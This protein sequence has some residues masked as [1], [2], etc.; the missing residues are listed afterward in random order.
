MSE[1]ALNQVADSEEVRGEVMKTSL[2]LRLRTRIF[3]IRLWS[4]IRE[5]E[6]QGLW[7]WSEEC[8][9]RVKILGRMKCSKVLYYRLETTILA[10][11]V[12]YYGVFWGDHNSFFRLL[13]LTTSGSAYKQFQPVVRVDRGLKP[14][15]NGQAARVMRL[16][17][18]QSTQMVRVDVLRIKINGPRFA[19][20]FSIVA[21]GATYEGRSTCILLRQTSGL[22]LYT[23]H[24]GQFGKR[25][26][27]LHKDAI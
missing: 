11:V 20:Q 1:L 21:T 12:S 9:H 4:A 8:A 26:L 22:E 19:V 14:E 5:S 15:N 7:F 27:S 13:V 3:W 23:R 2:L 24:T 10:N 16:R 18:S 17:D 6:V 25:S